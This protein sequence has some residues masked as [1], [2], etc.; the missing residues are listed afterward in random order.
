M[1]QIAN[2]MLIYRGSR[3]EDGVK[4]STQMNDNVAVE[5]KINEVIP[6]LPETVGQFTGS[7]DCTGKEVYEGDI[8]KNHI[9]GVVSI[10]SF[11]I[12]DTEQ[13]YYLPL[14]FEFE[15]IDNIY[16]NKPNLDTT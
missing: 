11:E 3:T 16:D 15:V 12:C 1:L 10:V 6:I 13:G 4:N 5:L 9:T 2:S 8:I 14:D 7:K